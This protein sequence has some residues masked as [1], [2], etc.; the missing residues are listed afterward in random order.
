MHDGI[1]EIPIENRPQREVSHI[2]GLDS[3]GDLQEV[4]V[5]PN[6]TPTENPAFDVTPAHLISGL[7]TER[8]VTEASAASLAKLFPEKASPKSP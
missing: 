7:I 2:W 8:G 1:A 4:R 5:S 6:G 3:T